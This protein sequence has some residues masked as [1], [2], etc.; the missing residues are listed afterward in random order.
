MIAK[1]AVVASEL[2]EDTSAI[3]LFTFLIDVFITSDKAAKLVV[4][5]VLSSCCTIVRKAVVASAISVSFAKFTTAF[6]LDVAA[7]RTVSTKA[8]VARDVAL[9]ASKPAPSAAAPS[10]LIVVTIC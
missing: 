6:S 10:V 1:V 8:R 3:A 5:I 7:L 2:R 9:S 4:S